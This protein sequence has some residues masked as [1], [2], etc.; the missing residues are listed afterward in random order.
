MFFS[1]FQIKVPFGMSSLAN[2]P[3]TLSDNYLTSK[4][5]YN[6]FES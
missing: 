3:S 6:P 5:T 4:G 2:V 1:Y